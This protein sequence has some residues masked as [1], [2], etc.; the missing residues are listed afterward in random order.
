MPDPIAVAEKRAKADL[1]LAQA[2]EKAS[3]AFGVPFKTSALP[4]ARFPAL[5]AAETTEGVA[6]FL[7][8]ITA[9]KERDPK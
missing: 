3:L 6:E 7:E 5:Y 4:A 1:R 8:T 2:A 9:R